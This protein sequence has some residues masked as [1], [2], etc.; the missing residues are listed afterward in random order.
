MLC[1]GLF[2]PSFASA[3]EAE[4]G[5]DELAMEEVVVTGM[6]N[7]LKK[8]I[9][10]K[11]NSSTVVDAITAEDIGK[12][13]DQNIAESLQRI[14]GVTIDRSGGEGQLLTV[15]GM[16]PEFN[17]T[18]LNGRTL[19]T[20]SGGR[21]F[22]FDIMASELVSGAEVHKTQSAYLQEGSIGATVNIKTLKP[23]D[24]PGF[25]AVGSVKGLYDGMTGKVKPQVSGLISDT[26]ADDTFGVLASFSYYN[27]E[28]RY[29]KAN[30]AYYR[31]YDSVEIDGQTYS[32]IYFPRNY[33]QIAQTETRER[34]SGTLVL[35]Y[36]PTDDVEITADALYSKLDVQYRQDVFPHWF[37]TGTAKNPVFDD[38]NTVVKADFEGTFVESLVRQSDAKNEL[39][40]GG[41][42]V[43]WDVSENWKMIF[44]VSVSKAESDPK[45]G[46]SDT[47]IG[48]PGDFSYD[49]S[50]G[51]LV[52]TMG[53]S[54]F[55]ESDPLTAGWGSLQGTRIEDEV[56]EAKFDNNYFI[57]D[58]GPL[59]KVGFGG[60]FSNRT[61]G[62]T[63][64]E[65]EY[66]LPW[67]FADNS[68]RIVL[69]T[70]MFHPYDAD[71]FLSGASGSPTETWPTYDSDEFLNFLLSEEAIS[72]LDDPEPIRELIAR[73]GG[74][75]M[76]PDPAAY[77]VNEKVK[78]LYVDVH[79]EGDVA[80]MPWS[81]VA[82]LR[83]VETKSKSIGQ[84]VALL[85]LIP[86]PTT[87]GEVIAIRSDDYV[88][89][90]VKN[91]YHD[92]L[93][94]L[95]AKL[96]MTDNVIARFAFSKSLTRPELD[97]M[98]PLTSY[99]GGSLDNLTGSGSNPK[100]SPYLSTNFDLSLEWYYSDASY[101]AVSG[102]HKDID[103][104]I[105][106]SEVSETVVLTSGTY[107]YE[108]SRP[109]NLHS[110][111]IKGIEVAAQHMFT[112]LPSP[113]DGLGIMANATFLDSSSSTDVEGE[114]LPLI[115][116]SDSQ[117]LILFYEKGP[118]QARIA[119]NNRDRFMQQ[120]P[121]SYRDGHYVDDYHQIDITASYD[122]DDNFT[123]FFEGI[124]I[125]NELYIT[126]AEYKNQIIEVI[127]NGPR[128]S[129][130]IRGKF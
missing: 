119:Y 72:Q 129:I 74:F 105:G 89:V 61:L 97:E 13:P 11:K 124:N 15:R 104:Y 45:K 116:L 33:D 109:V 37:T 84:Q 20:T 126:T 63:Y 122:I 59:V 19:A 70:S 95:N 47:V 86:A 102:F 101:V 78:A 120:K 68:S 79:L 34:L 2:L 98:S 26:F 23:M 100:L 96:N 69:P 39:I 3:Q 94:S 106:S 51:D 125:T 99:S 115:G 67:I 80:D 112:S 91:T 75:T 127:E 29:D 50:A 22:S 35:Q 56:L 18:L 16:G 85:D 55:D 10:Y 82:G 108:I 71:G 123:V 118:F 113:F 40:A 103:G 114:K 24:F 1:S 5:M 65:T 54:N 46:W 31:K 4:A 110:T 90:E 58:A 130:G 12:F 81:V 43:D 83:Y 25:Q 6:R 41:F 38:N 128:Y 27:R 32:D 73:T 107:N 14:T 60:M 76:I 62:S 57:E 117:N 92:F 7:S 9:D 30:T 44:D 93:P 36:R 49:R 28:S 52:P 66:P 87:P 64:G 88:P 8:S 121:L 48:R 42:N 17:S 77:E 53:Y 111:K 21:A